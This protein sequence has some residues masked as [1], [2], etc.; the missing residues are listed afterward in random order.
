[1]ATK[2]TGGGQSKASKTS[3]EV[4]EVQ[5]EETTDVAERQAKEAGHSTADELQL[6]C[7]HGVLHLLGMDH[8]D[9]REA[10]TPAGERAVH[11]ALERLLRDRDR[12]Q[13]QHQALHRRGQ[14]RCKV[15]RRIGGA[16][17]HGL[18]ALD[19]ADGEGGGTDGREGRGL[20]DRDLAERPDT[21]GDHRN[22]EDPGDQ[23]PVLP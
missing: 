20:V 19:Q 5:A 17:V 13:P 2:D 15:R 14:C 18:A 8:E 10:V 6:L 11:L 22:E 9:E 16:Q 12:R 21:H 3:E 7:T 23:P 4:E 1:M